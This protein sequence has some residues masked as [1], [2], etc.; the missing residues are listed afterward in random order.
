MASATWDVI[1]STDEQTGR[2]GPA[3]QL[4]TAADRVPELEKLVGGPVYRVA[5]HELLGAACGR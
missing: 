2:D 3:P 1:S 5:G 4:W